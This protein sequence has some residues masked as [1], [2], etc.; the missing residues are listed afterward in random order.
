MLWLMCVTHVPLHAATQ[1]TT[2]VGSLSGSIVDAAG[3]P[4]AFATICLVGTKSCVVADERGAFRLLNL[5]SGE[6]ALRV[7][8]LTMGIVQHVVLTAHLT[9]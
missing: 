8:F 1:G 3:A 9:L 2:G 6:Y 7:A 5:R 4:A